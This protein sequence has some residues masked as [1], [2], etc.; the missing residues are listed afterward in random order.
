ML[1]AWLF[2]SLLAASVAAASG[3]A[4]PATPPSN[5]IGQEIPQARL[6]GEGAYTWFGLTIYH[7]QLWVGQQGYRA[8]APEAAPFVLD[9]RYARI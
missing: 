8:D 2:G 9:L 4:A 3:L 7:A 1:M 6:S 5:Y